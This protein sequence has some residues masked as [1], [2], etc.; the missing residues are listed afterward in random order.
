MPLASRAP[1]DAEADES[2]PEQRE[3]ARLRGLIDLGLIYL[4]YALA[5]VH[6]AHRCAHIAGTRIARKERSEIR[7][8][9][10]AGRS[11]SCGYAEG[12]VD[13]PG[14]AEPVI[15]IGRY[16]VIQHRN[17]VR[18]VVSVKAVEPPVDTE[19]APGVTLAD[20]VTPRSLHG[21]GPTL[22][23]AVPYVAETEAVVPT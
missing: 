7:D 23:V 12:T 3:A 19:S 20:A 17:R 6:R 22:C 1:E 9:V 15:G 8:P 18:A 5:G 2:D 4:V 14:A 11:G 13:E 10:A 21:K 16:T